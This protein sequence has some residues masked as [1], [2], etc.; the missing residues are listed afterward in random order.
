M[1]KLL[2]LITQEHLIYLFYGFSFFFSIG[3][4]SLKYFNCKYHFA[5]NGSFKDLLNGIL[6]GFMQLVLLF[7]AFWISVLSTE[8]GENYCLWAHIL[9]LTGNLYQIESPLKCTFLYME[10]RHQGRVQNRAQQHF[11]PSTSKTNLNKINVQ[12]CLH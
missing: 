10:D 11:S 5:L 9:L 2:F 8:W 3:I 7:F 4:A 1:A 12:Q 6:F